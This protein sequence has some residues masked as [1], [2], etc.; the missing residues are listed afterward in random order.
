ME[1]ADELSNSF[2]H[3]DKLMEVR[4]RYPRLCEDMKS[5]LAISKPV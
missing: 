4:T 1:S 2:P 3:A 5:R